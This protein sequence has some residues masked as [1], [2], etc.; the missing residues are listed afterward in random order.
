MLAIRASL[1]H[2]RFMDLRPSTNSQDS[3]LVFDV[4]KEILSGTATPE[5]F[6]AFRDACERIGRSSECIARVDAFPCSWP[7]LSSMGVHHPGA[8]FRDA[9]FFI[10]MGAFVAYAVLLASGRL[11]HGKPDLADTI[12]WRHIRQDRRLASIGRD[13]APMN[14]Q[15]RKTRVE[16][17]RPVA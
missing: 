7:R 5:R 17:P 8:W 12:L 2:T 6:A 9:L 13:S 10:A 3:A 11:Y 15:K 4:L 1:W 16:C 14:E